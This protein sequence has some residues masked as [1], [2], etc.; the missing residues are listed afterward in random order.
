MMSYRK[1][2]SVYLV[3]LGIVIFIFEF[4]NIDIFVQDYF[5]LK[6]A[7]RWVIDRHEPIMR[8]LFYTGSKVV[9][10]IIGVS[11]FVGWFLSYRNE[12]LK[13]LRRNF[14]L[15]SLSLTIVPL[16]ISGLKNF[17]NV[18][19]PSQ[20]I[21]YG[22]SLPRVKV[23]E[24]FPDDFYPTRRGRGW[25]AGHASGGFALMAL[26]FAFIKKS[27]KFIG[28]FIGLTAGWVM[29]L[30]QTFNGQH[31]LSHTI[32]TML[33]AWILIITINRLCQYDRIDKMRGKCFN[34]TL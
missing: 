23:F 26:Y 31:Y 2:I 22:G 3:L 15:M 11:C 24:S 20:T 5:Y 19:T 13:K 33:I 32:V 34:L 17:S 10:I 29:G 18:Y 12:K 7:H 1:Q 16:T 25:P 28:L 8:F 6:E 27:M 21:R 30:Y 14:I 9:I 4:T